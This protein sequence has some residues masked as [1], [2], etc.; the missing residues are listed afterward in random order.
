MF[1]PYWFLFAERSPFGRASPH[2]ATDS[3][4]RASVCGATV[5]PRW[6]PE[7]A[8]RRDGDDVALP[9]A[10]H[11]LARQACRAMRA[12]TTRPIS[13]PAPA[14]SP[15]PSISFPHSSPTRATAGRR[16]RPPHPPDPSK[17]GLLGGVGGN[18]PHSSPKV[19]HPFFP[20]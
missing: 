11:A 2:G 12:G 19:L 17:S 6:R 7:P 1:N 16:R 9:A 18:V 3:L 15:P 14:S 5:W 8:L 10:P 4:C 20:S 13:W